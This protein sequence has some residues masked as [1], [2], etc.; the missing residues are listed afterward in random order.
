MP[1][2]GSIPPVFILRRAGGI[3]CKGAVG[4]GFNR[5]GVGL[6]LS[7]SEGNVSLRGKTL[8]RNPVGLPG[9]DSRPIAPGSTNIPVSQVS[10]SRPGAPDHFGMVG[11]GALSENRFN[12]RS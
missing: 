3:F 9:I 12:G 4:V 6:V 8:S 5:C 7:A 11:S 10:E 2:S 1:A